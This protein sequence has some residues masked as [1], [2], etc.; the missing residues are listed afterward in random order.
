[1]W[2]YLEHASDKHSQYNS[3][4][5]DTQ[6]DTTSAT[7]L[8][9]RHFD[10]MNVR[11]EEL[12][13]GCWFAVPTEVKS[14]MLSCQPEQCFSSRFNTFDET[15][16]K[17]LDLYATKKQTKKA[18]VN[19]IKLICAGHGPKADGKQIFWNRVSFDILVGASPSDL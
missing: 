10:C 2:K 11:A 1:M 19:L 8:E 17:I 15:K 16:E 6:M 3:C 18:R 4:R 13:R 5:S 14:C 12:L 7:N 9:D